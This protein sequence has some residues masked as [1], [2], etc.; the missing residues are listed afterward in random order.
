[1]EGQKEIFEGQPKV[2]TNE[3]DE[4][5]DNLGFYEKEVVP[6]TEKSYNRIKKRL[7]EYLE[8]EI[9]FEDKYKLMGRLIA[10]KKLYLDK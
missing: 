7:L 6:F 8:V 10:L 1:M 4:E 2:Q 5:D 3:Y 9:S